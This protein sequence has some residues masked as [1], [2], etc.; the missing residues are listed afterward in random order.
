MIINHIQSTL[1]KKKNVANLKEPHPSKKI[2]FTLFFF[3]CLVLILIN[4]QLKGKLVASLN[5]PDCKGSIFHKP[6]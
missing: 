2:F 1:R 5:V 6:E 3:S 4:S